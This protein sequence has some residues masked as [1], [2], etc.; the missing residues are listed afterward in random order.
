MF[1]SNLRE[2]AK[3]IFFNERQMP[4]GFCKK[5]K[6]K[7][8]QNLKW[9]SK[10]SMVKPKAF[11]VLVCPGCHY[12]S[13]VIICCSVPW[14]PCLGLYTWYSICLNCLHSTHLRAQFVASSGLCPDVFFLVR[15]RT[16]L[17]KLKHIW[18]THSFSTSLLCLFS[19]LLITIRCNLLILF[20]LF[21]ISM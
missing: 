3:V 14:S 2:V 21:C 8:K 13:K 6:E 20:C 7:R 10:L 15:P 19:V 5:K 1:E 17:L 11:T 12:S 18:H 9:L 16:I 4:L